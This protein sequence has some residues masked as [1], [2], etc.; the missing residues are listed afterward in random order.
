MLLVLVDIVC[1]EWSWNYRQVR[2]LTRPKNRAQTSPGPKHLLGPNVSWA[3][4]SPEP[5]RPGPKRPE[6]K[7]PRTDSQWYTVV[8]IAPARNSFVPGFEYTR[9]NVYLS[10]YILTVRFTCCYSEICESTRCRKLCKLNAI[11]SMRHV[12]SWC[13]HNGINYIIFG[14]I[15]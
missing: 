11:H 10:S 14:R 6:P 1:N 9:L 5:K 4:T 12:T 3:Q 8:V 7:R 13:V 2:P 15:W